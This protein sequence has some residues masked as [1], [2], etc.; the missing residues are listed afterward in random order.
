MDGEACFLD[1]H[2]TRLVEGMKVLRIQHAEL[3]WTVPR[4][5]EYIRKLWMECGLP[6]GRAR[7]TVYRDSPGYFRPRTHEGRLH[8]ELQPVPSPGYHPQ[9]TRATP[10]TS[11]LRCARR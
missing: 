3:H 4:L 7:L 9:C 5:E 1:A 8:L 11:T 10:L 6:N 2:W